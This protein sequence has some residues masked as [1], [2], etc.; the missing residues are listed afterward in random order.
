MPSL[1]TLRRFAPPPR[2]TRFRLKTVDLDGPVAYAD[3][4]GEGPT[5]V[6]VHGLGGNHLN[7]LPA[8]PMLAK[9]ARVLAVDLIGFGRTPAAGR[10]FGM[11]AQ[12]Q[13]L[14]RFLEEIPGTPSVLVGNSMGGTL[15]L[16]VA[17]SAPDLVA[18]AVL[19]SPALPPPEGASFSFEIIRRSLVQALPGIGEL[20]MYWNGRRQGARGLFLDL[21]TLGTKDVSRV[22]PEVVE[23]NVS[24]I[25]DRMQKSPLGHAQ[26]YLQASRSLFFHLMQPGLVEGWARRVRSPVF[27]MHGADDQLVP[28]ACSKELHA[29]R[30]DFDLQILDDVGHVPQMEDAQRFTDS[31]VRWVRKQMPSVEEAPRS[32]A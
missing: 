25:A 20:A 13:M 16:Q 29:I 28:A 9:H 19:V 6:L 17:A 26:S 10:G 18:S 23:A 32:A 4:G 22:P 27:L 8:A 5:L 21:L 3:F 24:I 30:P 2:T 31:V 15:A 7:W 14:E 12:R 1:L 11:D